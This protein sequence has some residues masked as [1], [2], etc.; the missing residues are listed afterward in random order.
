MLFLSS[1]LLTVVDAAC[2]YSLMLPYHYLESYSI[3]SRKG[4]YAISLVPFICNYLEVILANHKS[5]AKR[6][7]QSLKRQ[8]RASQ[9][10]KS[11]RTF[12]KNLRQIVSEKKLDMAADLLKEYTSKIS[13]AAQKGF[14][15]ANTASRK[16]SRLASLVSGASK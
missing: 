1:Y 4:S 2:N 7:R 10:K 15:H 6:A 13:K 8:T 14:Y 16:I 9:T 3:L 5:A 11:V 12:E